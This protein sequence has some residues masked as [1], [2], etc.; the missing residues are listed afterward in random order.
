MG[1]RRISN[2]WLCISMQNEKDLTTPHRALV[3][4]KV[5]FDHVALCATRNDIFGKVLLTRF[6]IFFLV[7]AGVDLF[8]FEFAQGITGDPAGGLI[9]DGEQLF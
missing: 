5:H 6:L 3:S 9:I 2:L 1:H 7:Q 8:A 4:S